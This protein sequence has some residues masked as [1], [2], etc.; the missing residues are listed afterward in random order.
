MDTVFIKGLKAAS[1]IGCYD[2]E[3]DVRQTLVIDLEL[4]TDFARAAETDGLK[5]A[6]D[7][8]VISKRVIALCDESRF[9][10]LEAL[11]DRLA[12]VL[13]AEF[14]ITGLRMTITKP[15]A[16]PEAEGVGVVVTR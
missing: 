11:A 4:K 10:L 15:G 6:L 2:W 14:E 8:A 7:Y 3:R 9:Q 1:V 16:V 5:D 13:L 12:A